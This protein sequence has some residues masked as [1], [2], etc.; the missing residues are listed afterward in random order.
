MKKPRLE[1]ANALYSLKFERYANSRLLPSPPKGHCKW[2]GGESN[3]LYCCEQC[4]I[5]CYV[6]MG[7]VTQYILDRDNGICMKCG[8]DTYWLAREIDKLWQM[9]EKYQHFGYLEFPRSLGWAM[10][11]WQSYWEADHILAV[12]EGGGC[13]GLE[14][15]QTLCIPC[16]KIKSALLAK[17]RSRKFIRNRGW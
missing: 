11:T 3:L 2:C 5:E 14:N 10:K 12:R 4:R 13:C 17:Q 6:R 7:Y 15:F 9:E 1:M 8:L 16:H